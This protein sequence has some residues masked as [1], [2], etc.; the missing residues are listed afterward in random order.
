MAYQDTEVKVHQ[1]MPF[2][3]FD[4]E[5]DPITLIF[6][7]DLDMVK[8][9]LYTEFI[10]NSTKMSITQRCPILK[11][12]LDMVKTHL[13]TENETHMCIGSKITA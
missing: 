5:L 8:I 2:F 3:S 1:N 11:L 12:A 4:F 13:D 9:Y 6:K 10:T 7:L